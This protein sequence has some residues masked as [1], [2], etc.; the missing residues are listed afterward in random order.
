[1]AVRLAWIALS[2]V[3]LVAACGGGTSETT[4]TGGRGGAGG[5]GGAGG[6]GTGAGTS[7]TSNSSS[8]SSSSHSAS[9]SSGQ[10]PKDAGPDAADA[11]D[12]DCTV[13]GVPGY[14]LDTA[15]CDAMAN[16]ASTPGFCPG[17]ANIQCCTPYGEALCDPDVMVFPNAGNTTEA[18]GEGGCPDGMIP[19]D[20][21]CIDKYE[22]TLVRGDDGSSWSPYFNPGTIPMIARSV[23]DA[24]PQGYIDGDQAGE[25]CLNA[26]KRLCKDTEWLRAC[27]GPSNTTYPYGNTKM[28][29]VCNDHRDVHPAIQYFGTSDPSIY[30]HIDNACLNQLPMSVD[31]TGTRTGCVTAE[32]AYDM[33]GNLHE[34]TADPA[35][36]FRGGYY[37]DTVING[38]GCLYV[39]TAHNT[40]HW[41]YSTGF[42]CCA[43]P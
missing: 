19:V 24:V 36:T 3:S 23:A 29:G 7:S 39:T 40:L 8:H 20:T 43:D 33:M 22:A 11:G 4:S 28:L 10:P 31:P 18:P 27:R 2:V 32:G 21:F 14:C 15:A 12:Y 26:G 41:D 37:V 42:R 13:E 25:A 9:S 30:S 38:S 17:P 35:G 1:M 5:H 6:D 16:H 34:W